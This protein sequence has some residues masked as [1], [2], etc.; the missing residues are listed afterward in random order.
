MRWGLPKNNGNF[1]TARQPPPELWTLER[2]NYEHS[3]LLGMSI[4][5]KYP[6]PLGPSCTIPQSIGE[7]ARYIQVIWQ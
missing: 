1:P 6:Y 5:V 3:I 2:L 7:I 4:D